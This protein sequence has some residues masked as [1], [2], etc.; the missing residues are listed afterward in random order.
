MPVYNKDV[1]VYRLHVVL[2]SPIETPSTLHTGN[3]HSSIKIMY[4]QQLITVIFTST[5]L[6]DNPAAKQ[7]TMRFL[8]VIHASSALYSA[9]SW[10][11]PVVSAQT[12]STL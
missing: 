8:L 4:T 5:N 3:Q 9:G 6:C 1:P 2:D 12:L 7:L 11:R 10:N